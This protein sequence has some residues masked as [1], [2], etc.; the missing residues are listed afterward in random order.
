MCLAV[1]IASS[2]PLKTTGRDKANQ[3]F[4][5]TNLSTHELPVKKQFELP[6]VYYV[7]SDQGCGCGFLKDG[8]VGEEL[9]QVEGNYLQLSGYIA[10]ARQQG[11]EIQLFSCWEGDQAS[12]SEFQEVISEADLITPEFEFQEKALYTVR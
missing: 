8:V 6:N 10:D 9:T 5:V 3:E 1:Y 2:K 7:G 4:Y 12:R 11:A